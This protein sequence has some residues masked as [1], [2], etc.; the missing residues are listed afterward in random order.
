METPSSTRRVSGSMTLASLKNSNITFYKGNKEESDKSVS[1]TR[2]TNGKRQNER[3]ALIDLTNDSPIVGLAMETP[4]STVGQVKTLLQKVEEEGGCVNS[5]MG[6]LAPTPANTPQL[7]NLCVDRLGS[8]VIALPVVEEQWRT[9]M[10]KLQEAS[11]E[12]QKSVVTRSLLL[13]FSEDSSESYFEDQGKISTCKEEDGSIYDE[14]EVDG[15]YE[16]VKEVDV[17]DDGGDIDELCEGLS[18]IRMEEMFRGKHTRFVYNSDEMEREED[19]A[20]RLKALPTP[21]GKHLHFHL[22][23]E[24]E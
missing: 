23:E 13:D 16:E 18:K 19:D 7:S 8:I 17:D 4:S 6:I 1:K 12:S 14:D 2:T 3:A 5:S 20:M 15:Y 9:T 24:D 21:K 22:E 11:L 10:E